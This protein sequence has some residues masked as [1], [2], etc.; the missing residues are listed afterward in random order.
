MLFVYIDPL[1]KLLLSLVI[2]TLQL[3]SCTELTDTAKW[4]RHQ[5]L[6][7]LL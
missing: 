4:Q 2:V 5:I 1:K 6:L 7:L 3:F